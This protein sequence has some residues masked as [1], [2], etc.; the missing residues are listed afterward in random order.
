MADRTKT[1]A[2]SVSE[3]E[4]AAVRQAAAA[5]NVSMAEFVRRRVLDNLTVDPPATVDGTQPLDDFI[6][7]RLQADADADP[8]PKRAVY[9]AYQEFCEELYPDHEI[10]TQHKVSRE[11]ANLP[12]VSTGRAYVELNGERQHT[13]CFEGVRW[14]DPLAATP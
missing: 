7:A 1:V 5:E 4:K 9:T 11:I 3:R 6:T 2:F 13:R 10:E 14:S 8:L 12:D